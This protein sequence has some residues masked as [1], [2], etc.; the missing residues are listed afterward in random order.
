MYVLVRHNMMLPEIL[1]YAFIPITSMQQER[2]AILP[3]QCISHR[4]HR[5]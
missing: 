5:R 1:S 3:V 4:L 2:A